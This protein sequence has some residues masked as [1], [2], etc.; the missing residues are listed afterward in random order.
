MQLS[1]LRG[2]G[3]VHACLPTCLCHT[4][5]H[6][7]LDTRALVFHLLQAE[8]NKVGLQLPY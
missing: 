7:H 4:C 1:L 6:P 8:F 2:I 5:V 3:L